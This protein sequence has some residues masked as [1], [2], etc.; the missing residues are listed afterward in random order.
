M[1]LFD[2]AYPCD[3][4]LIEGHNGDC[5]NLEPDLCDCDLPLGHAGA[6][7]DWNQTPFAPECDCG[8][9]VGHSG[10]CQHPGDNKLGPFDPD[11]LPPF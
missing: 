3:C 4:G 7:D 10:P 9:V 11:E 1:A 2:P 6:C 5:Q 8:A